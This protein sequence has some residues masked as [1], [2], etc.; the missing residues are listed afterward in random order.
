MNTPSEDVKDA[1]ISTK[2]K[3]RLTKVLDTLTKHPLASILSATGSRGQAKAAYRM[4]ANGRFDIEEVNR[5]YANATVERIREHETVLLVQDTTTNNLNGHK[6]TEGLG[7][8]GELNKGALIHTCMAETTD[9]VP[10]GILAQKIWTRPQNKDTSMTKYEK[11]Q[12]PIEEKESYRW[13]ETLN[14][15]NS[16]IPA[17]V[18]AINICDREGDFYEFYASAAASNYKILVRLVQNRNIAQDHQKSLDYIRSAPSCGAISAKIPRDTRNGQKSRK[19]MLEISYTTV[20]FE[21]TK[22]LSEADL[23]TEITANAI[24]VIEKDP[25]AGI[26]A[27]EWFLLTTETVNS[28]DD[29]VKIVGYYIQRWKIER[30][31][32]VLKEGC[33]VEEVQERNFERQS[34]MIFICSMIA[35]YIMALTYAARVTPDI[36]C[37]IMFDEDEWKVL[38]C[39]ANKVKQAPATPYTIKEAVQYLAKLGRFKG[40]PSDGEPGVKVVWRGLEA[41]YTLM[42]YREYI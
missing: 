28:F 13:I 11:S 41:L 20:T 25:P 26:E 2:L 1:N 14:E 21:K 24:H 12:R 3:K 5:A 35:I 19:A 7:Y 18:N 30:F 29:A 39:A 17:E 33:K 4:L 8:C 10:L 32:Y 22:I 31:H 36:D 38:Y 23:P 6:K 9:G 34:S 16:L 15:A 42:E 27:I 37:S 40:A